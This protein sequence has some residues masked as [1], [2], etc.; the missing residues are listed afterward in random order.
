VYFQLDI[1]M[2]SKAKLGLQWHC[3]LTHQ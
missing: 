1:A 2:F 3:R